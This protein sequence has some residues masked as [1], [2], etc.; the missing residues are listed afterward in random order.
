[1]SAESP[2]WAATI[3]HALAC[4]SHT[5]LPYPCTD[6]Q[7]GTSYGFGI[8]LI[9]GNFRRRHARPVSYYALFKWWL[10]LSQHPGC[11]RTPTSLLTELNFGALAGN[12]G[13][14]PL[15][16]GAYPPWSDCRGSTDGIRSWIGFGTLVRALSQS[17]L[18][19]RLLL[20]RR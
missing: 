2:V 7:A 9:P 11:L 5:A 12:L 20:T 18:Y 14:F 8:Q 4:I 3:A 17:V 1:M 6:T 10:L 13:C 16:H 15:D 19:P